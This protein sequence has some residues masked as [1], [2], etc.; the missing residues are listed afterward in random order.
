L[1]IPWEA[2]PVEVIGERGKVADPGFGDVVG[3]VA[4]K[5]RL[6]GVGLGH[7]ECRL[8]EDFNRLSVGTINISI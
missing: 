6:G 2:D 7:G 4:D 5:D 1:G 8:F 3:N